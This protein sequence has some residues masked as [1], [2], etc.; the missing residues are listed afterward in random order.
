MNCSPTVRTD[1]D[2][3]QEPFTNTIRTP[4]SQAVFGENI[5]IEATHTTAT[6]YIY[7]YKYCKD[8]YFDNNDIYIY[9]YSGVARSVKQV[10]W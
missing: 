4:T 9:I 3:F 5:H 8:S 10:G 6:I 7:I 1:Q 2:T